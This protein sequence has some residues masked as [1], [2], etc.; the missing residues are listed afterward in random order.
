LIRW[1][2]VNYY[3]VAP[4]GEIMTW[5]QAFERYGD[6]G[7]LEGPDSPIHLGTVLAVNPGEI[8]PVVAARIALL[9]SAIGLLS[10][11][12]ALAAVDR[13]RP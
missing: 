10:A 4:T 6:P 13:R 9:Y 7:A 8:Y 12:L 2:V 11:V 3:V 5:Q 1:R